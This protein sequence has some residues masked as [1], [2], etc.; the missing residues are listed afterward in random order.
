[1]IQADMH[2]HSHFSTDSEVCPHDMAEAAIKKGLR[3]ICFKRV[4]NHLL[5]GSF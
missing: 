4:E 1:M 2:M 3:T 5:Y